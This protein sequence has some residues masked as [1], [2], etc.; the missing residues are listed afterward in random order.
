MK[1]F[2]LIV[3]C[4]SLLCACGGSSLKPTEE[5]KSL[6]ASSLILKGKHA[7]LF[8]LAGD[9]Y[10]VNLVKVNDSWQV[11]VK[12]TIATNTPFEEIKNSSNFERELKGP[13]GKL[14]NSSDVELESLEMNDSDW[15]TLIQEDEESELS[16]SGNTW[17]YKHLEY[18]RAKEIF[19]NTV[20]VEISG[21]E[22]EPLKK[23]SL[24]SATQSI[25][26]DEDVQDLKDAAETA[27]KLL[28]AEK[29]LL[30]AL[31]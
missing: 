8:K 22:L 20:A 19:D 28:E 21:L 5:S 7:K 30:N 29:E 11:R 13:Y 3:A 18:E 1:K 15:E 6:P 10:N 26:D 16:V 17:S 25:M 24:K 12:M 4:V 9:T 27:G 23:E 14:L 2:L 31:F